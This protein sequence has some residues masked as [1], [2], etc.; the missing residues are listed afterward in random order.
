MYLFYNKHFLRKAKNNHKQDLVKC[1]VA[2]FWYLVTK[3]N[4][5]QVS[6]S[7]SIHEMYV[8]Y[9]TYLC[10]CCITLTWFD[11]LINSEVDNK[12]RWFA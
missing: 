6:C 4:K 10:T 11:K 9:S 1:S 8:C 3:D 2:F 12:R 7:D 5:I